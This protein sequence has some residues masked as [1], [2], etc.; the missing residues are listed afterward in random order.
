MVAPP[1]ML[2]GGPLPPGGA[3]PREPVSAGH[4]QDD[5]AVRRLVRVGLLG[6]RERKDGAH[7]G[8]QH[9]AIDQ[10][11]DLL[12][13]APARLDDEERVPYARLARLLCR[14]G[15]GDHPPARPQHVPGARERLAADGI[16]H[17]VDVPH[18][19]LET[20]R[21][22]VDHLVGSETAYPLPA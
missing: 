1:P 15:D 2:A 5:L 13:L 8:P 19:V 20:V 7:D 21:A 17:D 22:I 9:A 10:R 14:R 11:R 4:L 18:A 16:E 6:L 12:E 3:T